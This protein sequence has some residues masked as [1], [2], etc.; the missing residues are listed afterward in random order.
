MPVPSESLLESVAKVPAWQ[1]LHWLLPVPDVALPRGQLMQ[2]LLLVLGWYCPAEQPMHELEV[3]VDALWYCPA[4][5][6][7]HVVPS[8][9]WPLEHSLL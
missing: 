9:R 3:C 8:S 7:R 1:M 4:A 5:H 2:P 6:E